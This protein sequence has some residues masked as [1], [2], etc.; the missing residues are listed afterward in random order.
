MIKRLILI[1][2]SLMVISCATTTN[3]GQLY[4]PRFKVEWWGIQL[5]CEYIPIGETSGQIQ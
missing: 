1:A 4:I 2:L 3:D 5:T